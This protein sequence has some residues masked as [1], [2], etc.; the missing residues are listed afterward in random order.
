MDNQDCIRVPL[1]HHAGLVC[2]FIV[3][4]GVATTAVYRDLSGD[5]DNRNFFL[6]LPQ[7]ASPRSSL[8]HGRALVRTPFLARELVS[9]WLR[10]H[11]AGGPRV[12]LEPLALTPLMK[13]PLPPP[14]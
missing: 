3:A 1:G 6:K 7:A 11:V 13:P 12:S 8:E 4:V 14:S 2:I 9:S 5:V 10:P